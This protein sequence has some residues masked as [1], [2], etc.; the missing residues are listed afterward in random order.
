MR[1]HRLS[2]ANVTATLAL[3][4]ALGGVSYAAGVLPANSVG[5]A[6]LKNDSV[7]SSKI[8]N[9]SI[10]SQDIN[11]DTLTSLR[12]AKGNTG[13][14]GLQGIQGLPGRD[15]AKGDPG[16]LGPTYELAG[17]TFS[18]TLGTASCSNSGVGA[19]RA[20]DFTAGSGGGPLEIGSLEVPAGNYLLL[21]S[22]TSAVSGVR[23][24]KDGAVLVDGAAAVNPCQLLD[25]AGKKVMDIP[26]DDLHNAPAKPAIVT[27]E[28]AGRLGLGCSANLQSGFSAYYLYSIPNPVEVRV[29]ASLAALSLIRIGQRNS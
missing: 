6:Q 5:N 15:G 10:T 1:K 3:F 29:D 22:T 17:G 26:Q 23:L 8:L 2:Y 18:F 11:N 4:I 28:T 20:C 7:N 9:R 16:G 21:R 27:V 13:D 25:S 24:Y 14:R 12:G 19:W